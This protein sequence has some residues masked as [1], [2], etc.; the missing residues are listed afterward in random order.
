MSKYSGKKL[1]FTDIETTG[2][3]PEQHEIIEIA[4]LIYNPV[5]DKVER[6]WEK[7]IAPKHIETASPVALKIN[8]YINNPDKYNGSLK[9]ALI[10][11]NSL[12]KDCMIIG[13]NIKFDTTFLRK[14]MAEFNIKPSFSRHTELDLMAIAWPAV[15]DSDIEGLSLAHLCDHFGVTNVGA[16]TALVDCRRTFGVYKCLMNMYKKEKS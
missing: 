11:F 10:K 5:T 1:A 14:Y 15:L 16:H 8:G 7:A 2:L 13:Q 12:A 3:D 4:T 6:E 9:S